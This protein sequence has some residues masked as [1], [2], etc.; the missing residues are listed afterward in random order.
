MLCDS[1]LPMLES[2]SASPEPEWRRGVPSALWSSHCVAKLKL[3]WDV[4]VIMMS[5]TSVVDGLKER[6]NYDHNS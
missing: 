1:I 6:L 5:K 4:V 3:L 2:D